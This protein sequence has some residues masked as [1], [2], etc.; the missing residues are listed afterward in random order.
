MGLAEKLAKSEDNEDAQ[1]A[2][3]A[4][5]EIDSPMARSAIVRALHHRHYQVRRTAVKALAPKANEAEKAALLELVTDKS[6][7]VRESLAVV[8][9]QQGWENGLETLVTLLG[10]CRNYARHPEFSSREEPEYHVARAAAEALGTFNTLPATILDQI[11]AFLAQTDGKTIDVVVHADLLH[12]LAYPEHSTVWDMIQHALSDDHVVGDK[13]ENLYPLRYAAG[14]AIV[15][16][17]S[18]YPFE[19]NLAPW[20]AIK[21]AVDHIDPQLAAPLPL[22]IGA[23][24]AVECDAETLEALRGVNTSNARVALALSMIDDHGQHGS[25]RPNTVSWR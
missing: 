9:G 12:L 24:L 14:W 6:G 21:A 15:K 13:E 2:V 20:T 25:W 10:D 22:S 17:I 7:P 3:R 23:Q 18:R 1:T 16:R 8:I 19:H 11:I 4:L 5:V